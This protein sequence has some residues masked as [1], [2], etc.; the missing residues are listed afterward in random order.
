MT[1]DAIQI[2]GLREFQRNLKTID[3]ELPKTLR[4]SFNEAADL[5]VQRARKRVPRDSGRAAKS[6]RASSTQ[7]EARV[8]GGGKR[9]PYYPWL[10]FGGRVGRN[11]STRRR[12]MGGGRYLY[13]S[14][15]ESRVE[16]Q[17]I[18]EENLIAVA[19][20]ANLPPEQ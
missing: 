18:L 11:L 9:A 5:V 14:L 1:E 6:V 10:D 4:K 15:G 8:K 2:E 19:E 16:L 17:R 20:R 13:S 12:Y 3:R 7:K